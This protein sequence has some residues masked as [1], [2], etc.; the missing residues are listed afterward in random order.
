[1]AKARDMKKAREAASQKR[2]ALDDARKTLE[3]LK[4]EYFSLLGS[5][6]P[7]KRGFRLEKIMYGL[8]KLFDLDPKASFKVE[9]EQ[10]DGGFTVNQPT[11]CWRRNGKRS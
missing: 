1:M 7:Q 9:G 5:Q 6:E 4:K 3:E 11:T 10:V 8:F 2:S